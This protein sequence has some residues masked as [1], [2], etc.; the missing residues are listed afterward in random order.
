[1]L[2]ISP[3]AAAKVVICADAYWVPRSEWNTTLAGRSQRDRHGQGVLDQVG[4][5]VLV[6][7]PADHPTRVGVDNRGQVQPPCH[8]R[9]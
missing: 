2:R 3:F 5:H 1:M 7:G 4:A 9:R 8:V 6:D